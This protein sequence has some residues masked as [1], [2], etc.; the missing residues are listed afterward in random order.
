MYLKSYGILAYQ[1]APMQKSAR[2]E[3]LMAQALHDRYCL[4]QRVMITTHLKRRSEWPLA[5]G[6][7]YYADDDYAYYALAA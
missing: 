3:V 6:G 7:L 5:C 4:S 2:Q 1:I